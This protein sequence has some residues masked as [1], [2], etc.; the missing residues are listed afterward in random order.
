MYQDM[1]IIWSLTAP[2]GCWSG[3]FRCPLAQCWREKAPTVILQKQLLLAIS[4]KDYSQVIKIQDN[5]LANLHLGQTISTK[6]N[7]EWAL[8]L[9]LPLRDDRKTP[10]RRC[11]GGILTR[12]PKPPQLAPFDMQEQQFCSMRTPWQHGLGSQNYIWKNHETSATMS[13]GPKRS[14]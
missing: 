10:K 2:K 11:P 8:G 4:E 9:L 12:C 1:K 14:L 7:F 3:A 13:F 6:P 5:L